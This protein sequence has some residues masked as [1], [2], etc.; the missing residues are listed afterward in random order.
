MIFFGFKVSDKDW[1]LKFNTTRK[2]PKY[3]KTSES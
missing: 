1:E 3:P 2:Y